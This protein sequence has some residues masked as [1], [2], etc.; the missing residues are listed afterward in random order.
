MQDWSL[1]AHMA[2]VLVAG[3]IVRLIQALWVQT[4]SRKAAC[5]V[6]FPS[7]I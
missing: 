1:M 3:N 6:F 2:S 7:W 5:I 4:Q